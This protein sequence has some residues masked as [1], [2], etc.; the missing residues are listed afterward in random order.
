[1]GSG[2]RVYRRSPEQ[3]PADLADI[4]SWADAMEL[5]LVPLLFVLLFLLVLLLCQARTSFSVFRS[6]P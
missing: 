5:T 4:L 6:R 1:V 3:D 2:L